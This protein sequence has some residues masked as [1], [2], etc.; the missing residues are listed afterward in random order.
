MTFED[1]EQ[2]QDEPSRRRPGNLFWGA[3]SQV[4]AVLGALSM[5]VF[6]SEAFGLGIKGVL[7]KLV[8]VWSAV[9]RPGVKWLTDVVVF[10]FGWL[11]HWNIEVPLWL[12]DYLSVGLILVL[13][14][15]RARVAYK[16]SPIPERA[17]GLSL[18]YMLGALFFWP[19]IVIVD[20]YEQSRYALW[21]Y[22]RRKRPISAGPDE[23]RRLDLLYRIRRADVVNTLMSL[24]PLFYLAVLLI[25]NYA[26]L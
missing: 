17:K 9:V 20:G 1:T 11:F 4:S 12:R 6:L 19:L 15:I 23:Q 3:Y 13:S 16:N 7:A 5:L 10:P 21:L 18:G 24:S 22:R 14:S 8:S 26:V 2:V 25:V